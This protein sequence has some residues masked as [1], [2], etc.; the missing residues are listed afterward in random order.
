MDPSG[1]LTASHQDTDELMNYY[2]N[3]RYL[4]ISEDLDCHQNLISF[5]LHYD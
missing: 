3:F 4:L 2:Q 5:S 1:S